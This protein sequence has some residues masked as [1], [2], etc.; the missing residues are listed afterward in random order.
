MMFSPSPHYLLCLGSLRNKIN[1]SK[2]QEGRNWKIGFLGPALTGSRFSESGKVDEVKGPATL[3]PL[4]SKK[5]RCLGSFSGDYVFPYLLKLPT[6]SSVLLYIFL[7]VFQLW[8][9]FDKDRKM[10]S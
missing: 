8:L 10:F 4:S 5:P 2:L 1:L 6:S 3:S 7:K 9:K